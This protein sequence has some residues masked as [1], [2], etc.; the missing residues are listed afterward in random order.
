MVNKKYYIDSILGKFPEKVKGNTKLSW[1]KT[2]FRV[3]SFKERLGGKKQGI[4][5]CFVIK[6]LCSYKRARSDIN[7]CIRFLS[8]K[9]KEANVGDWVKL[10]KLL[11]CLKGATYNVLTLEAGDTQELKRY[12]WMWCLQYKQI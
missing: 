7:P 5:H 4:C 6:A 2:L 3:D 11:G 8:T 10:I 12:V 9:V 1:N